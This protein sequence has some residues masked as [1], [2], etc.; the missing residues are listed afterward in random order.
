MS[1]G[2]VVPS[3]SSNRRWVMPPEARVKPALAIREV[4]FTDVRK[5]GE[6]KI[7]QCFADKK[8]WSHCDARIRTMLPSVQPRV[9]PSCIASISFTRRWNLAEA[10]PLLLGGGYDPDAALP[11]QAVN[12]DYPLVAQQMERMVMML[13][14]GKRTGLSFACGN[15]CLFAT[16]DPENPVVLGQ[17]VTVSYPRWAVNLFSVE[18]VNDWHQDSCLNVCNFAYEHA[19]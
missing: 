6:R 4:V 10:L 15:F 19:V 1:W 18:C 12:A 13:E 7:D 14:R 11:R 17:I 3:P 9:G 5:V 2:N 8:I 16:N